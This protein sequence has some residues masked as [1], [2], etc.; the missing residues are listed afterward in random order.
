MSESDT[1]ECEHEEVNWG[2]G[3]RDEETGIVEDPDYLGVC[4]KCDAWMVKFEDG[5]IETV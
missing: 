2:D 5:R 1:I 3:F 4:N